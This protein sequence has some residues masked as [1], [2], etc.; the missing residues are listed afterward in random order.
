M[1]ADD[2]ALVLRPGARNRFGGQLIAFGCRQNA[3][4]DIAP[5]VM[6]LQEEASVRAIA[7]RHA[8][9]P[10]VRDEEPRVAG[11]GQDRNNPP[12]FIVEVVVHAARTGWGAAR[13]VTARYDA[14][15]PV[16]DS[17]V[18]QIKVHADSKHG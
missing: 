6:H 17:A 5:A 2:A 13:E 3:L 11:L 1:Q 15:G 10:D 12:T 4:G 8:T 18:L 16:F 7:R 14:G 9:V